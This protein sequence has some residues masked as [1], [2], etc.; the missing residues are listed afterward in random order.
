MEV[1]GEFL[2]N[3]SPNDIETIEV[4]RS[5][6]NTAIYGSRGSGGV[7]IITTK[8]GG[9]E[10]SYNNYAPGIVVVNPKGFAALRDFYSPKYDNATITNRGDFRSTV[11]WSPQVVSDKDGKAKFDFYNADEAATYRVVI[12]GIDALGHLGR[13]VYTYDVK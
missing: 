10:V 13:K 8:R 3:L 5:A 1:E 6:G 4:L 12:E 9:G 11:F 7:I 2:D